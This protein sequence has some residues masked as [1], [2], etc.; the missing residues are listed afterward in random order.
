MSDSGST[1]TALGPV[2]LAALSAGCAGTPA[3]DGPPELAGTSWVAEDIDGRGVMDRLQSTI[4]FE[5]S[6]RIAGN[7]GCNR[8]FGNYTLAGPELELGPLGSTMMA[9]PEAVMDQ[10]R[11]FLRAL[12]KTRV[13][14]LD[15]ETD[16]L[17]FSDEA[18][19]DVLRFS[20]LE[21]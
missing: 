11:R 5:S 17:Y 12:E 14:R 15:P 4:S 7:A 1:K 13:V 2:L 10:E 6:L 9:C 20:R 3:A 19:R 8:Y 16:L 18:G 21:Q